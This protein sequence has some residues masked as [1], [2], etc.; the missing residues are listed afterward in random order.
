MRLLS[1][2]DAMGDEVFGE[3]MA[4]AAAGRQD[5]IISKEARDADLLQCNGDAF[6]T[7]GNLENWVVLVNP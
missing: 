4:R 5:F 2:F 7:G 1:Y 6:L 3:Y